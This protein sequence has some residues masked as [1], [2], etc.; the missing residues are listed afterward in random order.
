LLL[1]SINRWRADI[2]QRIVVW[3]RRREARTPEAIAG[4]CF[5]QRVF[6]LLIILSID[7]I[8]WR[9]FLNARAEGHRP[10]SQSGR[11]QLTFSSKSHA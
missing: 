9:V 6:V 11:L 2:E 1:D 7:D 3:D 8:K 5:G 4:F 10:K